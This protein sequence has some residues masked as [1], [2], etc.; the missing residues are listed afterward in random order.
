LP[1]L[2]SPPLSVVP[3]LFEPL[4]LPF[5]ALVAVAPPDPF[6]PAVSVAPLL[7]VV[8][9]PPEPRPVVVVFEL[10][11]V[12]MLTDGVSV[13]DAQALN[14]VNKEKARIDR[15]IPKPFLCPLKSPHSAGLISCRANDCFVLPTASA[16]RF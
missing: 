8:L 15:V 14:S 4:P 9:L 10:P 13:F 6:P 16:A 11:S 12:P 2:V 3:L 5:V 1:E 7:V